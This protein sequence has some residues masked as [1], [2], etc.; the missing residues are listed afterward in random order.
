M[1]SSHSC[2]KK[3]QKTLLH[4]R[5]FYCTAENFTTHQKSQPYG[6]NWRKV[7]SAVETEDKPTLQRLPLDIGLNVCAQT[8]N[9]RMVLW[10]PFCEALDPTSFFQ[11]T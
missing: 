6:K 3:V 11:K 1:K 9:A 5:K 4:S 2:Y 7:P 10:S 8:S